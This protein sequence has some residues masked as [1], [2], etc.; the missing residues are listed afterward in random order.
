[1]GG[2]CLWSGHL[3]RL[4][5]RRETEQPGWGAAGL[6]SSFTEIS[7]VDSDAVA[8]Y[9]GFAVL[10]GK[11]LV[12]GF[13]ADE[14]FLLRIELEQFAELVFGRGEVEAEGVL[15][16]RLDPSPGLLDF[17]VVAAGREGGRAGD[18]LAQ[19]IGDIAQVAKGSRE[20]GFEYTRVEVLFAASSHA[21]N[22]VFELVAGAHLYV[23][24]E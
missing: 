10:A 23:D 24:V 18:F 5:E 9:E 14:L 21:V 6:H 20:M 15:Q 11:E 22:E 19:A 7:Q 4:R 12:G 1:M 16:A 8:N 13:V 2:S 3:R 17:W